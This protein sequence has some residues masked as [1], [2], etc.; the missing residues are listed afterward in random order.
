MK[1]FGLLAA[2][3]LLIPSVPSTPAMAQ[4]PRWGEPLCF[5]F[6]GMQI[7]YTET[8]A[9]CEYFRAKERNLYRDVG[10]EVEQCEPSDDLQELGF[11]WAF[12]GSYF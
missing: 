6:G 1:T 9:Q 11:R 2:T 12:F 4:S 5:L 3:A 7:C 10:L 8:R